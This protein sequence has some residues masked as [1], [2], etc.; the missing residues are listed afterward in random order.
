MFAI[1]LSGLAFR[2]CRISQPCFLAVESSERI[3][4]N[5]IAPSMERNPPEIFWRNFIIRPSR[6]A[7]LLLNGTRGSMRK[8][9]TSCLR[10]LSRSKYPP[11]EP[12][13]LRLRAPQ[14]G[15]FATDHGARECR[16]TDASDARPN[17]EEHTP[18]N[19]KL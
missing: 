1:K 5:S 6:S 17:G 2:V 19:V 18:G 16:C 3:T 10:V 4:A 8:R 9:S 14:R 11:A 7:R 13:A 12:E 15:L